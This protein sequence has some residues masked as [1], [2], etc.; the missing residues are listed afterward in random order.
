MRQMQEFHRNMQMMMSVMMQQSVQRSKDAFLVAPLSHPSSSSAFVDPH[1]VDAATLA[2]REEEERNRKAAEAA[3]KARR[4][5]QLTQD[6][7]ELLGQM[8]AT[9]GMLDEQKQQLSILKL[10]IQEL[11]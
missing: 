9:K 1:Q 5:S 6:L 7:R 10:K 2:R 3:E 4:K 11:S 8:R